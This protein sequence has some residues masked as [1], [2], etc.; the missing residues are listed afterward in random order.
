MKKFIV[1][2]LSLVLFLAACGSNEGK[3]KSDETKSDSTSNTKTFKQDDG[4]KVKIPK[5]PKRI[6]VLHP[7]Y[8]GALVEFGHKPVGVLDFVKQNKTLDEATKGA[9]RVGQENIE[10]IA[11]TKPDLI[12]T[13]KEDKNAKKLKKIAATVQLDSMNSDYKEVTKE[14]GSIV[15]EQD[16][17]DKWVKDWEEKLE[18]DKKDLGNKV[19]GKTITVIQSSP[20]GLMAFGKSLGRGTEIIYDGYGMSM[21]EKLDKKIKNEYSM[22]ISEEELTEYTGDYI[23]LATMGET[24]QFTK[25]NNW[26]N[27]KA[28][29]EGHVITLDASNTAYNDPISLE[30]QREIILKQLKDMK[31]F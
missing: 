20:K 19:D 25:T 6:V 12:I 31:K 28:V 22:P 17:A 9:T 23:I 26:K 3:E 5:E 2:A 18:Q 27:L 16:K 15:N 29:K 14:L 7:T 24:P 10:Q 11:K 1:F 13:T 8:I 21:P 4:K 30:K